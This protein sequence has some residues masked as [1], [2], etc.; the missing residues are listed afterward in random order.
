MMRVCPE[1]PTRRFEYLCRY[2]VSSDYGPEDCGNSKTAGW[3][4]QRVRWKVMKKPA[5]EFD[6]D[7]GADQDRGQD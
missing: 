2:S 4:I 5:K 6:V 7:E 3:Q 1:K